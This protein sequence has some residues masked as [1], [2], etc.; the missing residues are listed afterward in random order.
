MKIEKK[1]YI[2]ALDQ[3]TTSSRAIIFNHA[4]EIVSSSQK[5]F[6]QYYPE[7]GWVE[8]D[9][10]E[11]WE[12]QL[13]VAQ[14]AIENAKIKPEEIVSVG[15]SNQ[16]ET[17]VVW[18]KDSGKPVYKAIVWQC[19]RSTSICEELIETGLE[20]EFRKRTGLRLDPY[21]SGTKLCW[22]FREVPGLKALAEN[23]EILFGT[24]DCWLLWKLTGRHVTDIT[25]ASRTLIYNIT[26]EK[27][28][29]ILLSILGIPKEI[30]PEVLCSS[31]DFGVTKKEFFG[32]EL[33]ING[34]AGDQQAALFGHT[35]FYPGMAKNTYGTGCFT[36]LN[37]G[38]VPV[39]S[40]NNLLTTIAWKIGNKTIYALEGSVFIAGAV[41][42]WLRDE[43]GLISSAAE[44]DTLA[45]SVESTNGVYLVP[46]F[47]GLGAPYWDPDARGAIV[48]LSRGSNK[49][50][51]V[52]AALESIAYQSEDLLSAMSADCGQKVEMLKADGGATKNK[53]LMQFQSDISGIP[54]LL[55]EISEITALG[56]AYLAGLKCGF[57]E[58][59]ADIEKIWQTKCRYDPSMSQT[60]REKNLAFW[61]KAVHATREYTK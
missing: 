47:V 30:L 15:I 23:G 60:K 44:S 36:L 29:P 38:S 53:F 12:T 14:E 51:I 8:H 42:Q 40:K 20:E 35:C 37:T 6:T 18:D 7:P 52:R 58:N 56:A 19:R 24:I 31:D 25:N 26:E 22:L 21:F 16:R 59:F 45:L 27:W 43:L 1:G 28:D 61:H 9:P 48:G 11:I 50:H 2:L 17:V 13:R 49:A 55:P 5:D 33:P 4:G 39:W 54:V 10:I 3:G 41:I 57:W 46:G 32:C 34:V